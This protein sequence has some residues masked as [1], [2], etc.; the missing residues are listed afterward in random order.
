MVLFPNDSK[1]YHCSFQN[2]KKGRFGMK[3]R[4]FLIFLTYFLAVVTVFLAIFGLI[5][6]T[7]S[8]NPIIVNQGIGC[9]IGSVVFAIL[10]LVAK[11][12][13]NNTN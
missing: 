9:E 12:Q 4:E 11:P 2:S 13:A 3:N 10:A 1:I 5:G 8:S 7:T 6:I